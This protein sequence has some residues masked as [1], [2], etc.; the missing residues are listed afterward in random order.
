[1]HVSQK[2]SPNLS[3]LARLP[4]FYGWVILGVCALGMFTSGPGQTF[5][6][7]IFVD[8]LINDLGLSRSMV[9]GLYTAGSLT[10]ALAMLKLLSET[11]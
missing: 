11:S 5:G 9:S 2:P 4:V 8:P 7:S 6:I 1:M 10:A 3:R